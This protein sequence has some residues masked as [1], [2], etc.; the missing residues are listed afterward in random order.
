MAPMVALTIS[1]NALPPRLTPS[2]GSSQ[3]ATSAPMMPIDD[4]SDQPE[5]RA[6]HDQAGEPAGDRADH[7][8][9]YNTHR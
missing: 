5:T 2:C 1:R 9:S 3:L 4:V 8:C 6:A 7:E